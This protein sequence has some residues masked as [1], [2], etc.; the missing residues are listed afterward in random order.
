MSKCLSVHKET[1]ISITYAAD[2]IASQRI[3][4]NGELQHKSQSW[5]VI[6][7]VP[8]FVRMSRG[9]EE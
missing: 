4:G 8:E 2:V 7:R 6:M 9:E 5:A 3:D 1:G